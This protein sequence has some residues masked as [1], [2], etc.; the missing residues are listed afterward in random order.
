MRMKNK[1]DYIA[2]S[3]LTLTQSRLLAALLR[4]Q[5]RKVIES[6][7]GCTHHRQGRGF[8]GNSLTWLPARAQ[9][10]TAAVRGCVLPRKR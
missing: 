2:T 5:R 6:T 10:V 3:T 4:H 8:F 1:K 7:Q 9:S